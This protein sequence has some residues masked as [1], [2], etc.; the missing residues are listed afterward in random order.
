MWTK[1]YNWVLLIFLLFSCEKEPENDNDAILGCTDL[2]AMNYNPEATEEDGSCVYTEPAFIEIVVFLSE[3]CPIAQYMTLPLKTAY[4]DFSSESV[5]F[6]AY[7]PNL[8]STE[9]T[10]T[11]FVQKYDIP[12][13]C[14]DDN[15]GEIATFFGATVYSEVFIK[16]EGNLIYKGMIDDSYSALGQWSPAQNNYLYNIL[17]QIINGVEL[18]YMETEAIGC[19]I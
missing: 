1:K 15:G 11:G 9:K 10:I 6:K 3:T 19:L 12:F 18:D 14:I 17:E 16:L 4:E 13:I 7:F 5:Q 8:L 2:T